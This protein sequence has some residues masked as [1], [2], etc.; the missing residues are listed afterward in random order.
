MNWPH[1][2]ALRSRMLTAAARVRV[3]VMLIQAEND[4]DLGPTRELWAE[5]TRLGKPCRMRIY[6]PQGDSKVDGHAFILTG[7][8]TWGEEVLTFIGNVF[9]GP[10][11]TP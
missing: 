7:L 6:P 1:N 10:R 5:M 9:R 2:T 11:S 4:F 8:D 3:P